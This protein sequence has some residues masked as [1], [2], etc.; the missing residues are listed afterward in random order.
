MK[1]HRFHPLYVFRILKKYWLLML[2]PLAAALLRF[3][4]EGLRTALLAEAVTL[5]ALLGFS[6]LVWLEAYWY[7]DGT[8]LT[9]H[10]GVLLHKAL[11]LGAEELS[12]LRLTR[13]LRQRM[14]GASTLTL[15]YTLRKGKT[16]LL[17]SKW[18]AQRLMDELLPAPGAG[19]AEY[20]PKGI[21]RLGLASVSGNVLLSLTLMGFG[22][23]E[24]AQTLEKLSIIRQD[25][26][27]DAA[28]NG[29][30]RVTRLLSLWL[31]IGVAAAVTLIAL[32]VTFYLAQGAVCT[33]RFRACAGN[34]RYESRSGAI[35]R[36]I[37]RARLDRV[38]VVDV[39]RSPMAR[40]TGC[41]PVF[42]RAGSFNEDAVPCFLYRKGREDTLE[43]LF[44]GIRVDAAQAIQPIKGRSIPAFLAPPG[45][46]AG[47]GLLL[48]LISRWALP[49]ISWLLVLVILF[50]LLW[51][52]VQAEAFFREGITFLE[53]GSLLAV[54]TVGLN[55]H[56]SWVLLPEKGYRLAQNPFILPFGRC[57]VTLLL[58]GRQHIR[59][60]SLLRKEF[61]NAWR[62]HNV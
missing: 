2:L 14:L 3:D 52:A 45:I 15:Y 40:L 10:T 34:G 23:Y 57:D 27:T 21:E 46:M 39:R 47:V 6:V 20:V 25:Q 49:Q 31:P 43:S 48:F 51:M 9:V 5:L 7:W 35:G 53:N 13:N 19:A 11:V 54:T 36:V 60:R 56:W 55:H 16:D 8:Q 32:L 18:E 22:C 26:L 62:Y 33:L 38:A 12:C 41:F 29:F 24:A 42:L 37:F 44:P 17:L 1:K 4:L 59:V 58:P 30:A 61:E 50:G 28:L